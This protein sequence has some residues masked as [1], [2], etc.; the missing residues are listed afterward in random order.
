MP[1]LRVAIIPVSPYQQNCSLIF[2][3]ETK[4]GAVVDPGGDLD[5]IEA[6]IAKLGLTI[7]KILLT[8]GHT[9][10]AGG[11]DELRE[12]LGVTIEGPHRDDQWLLDGLAERGVD[13]GMFNNRNVVPD[14]YLGDGDTV[15]VA[16]FVFEIIHAPG[17]SPGSVVFF[18][19]ENGFALMG[20][21][22][23]R[24]SIGRTDLPRGNHE[25]L[26][27]SIH[28]KV[29]PL[30]DHVQFLPGHGPASSIGDERLNNPFLQG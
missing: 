13:D 26:L 1:K 4:R 22:L 10:H 28:E 11:A 2:D 25:T 3:E 20:D 9:D 19:R 24:N 12:K 7:E 30:G 5:R 6:A 29:L 21:V 17:H 16:G 27:K 23:F 18:N 8:H 15:E 14:R